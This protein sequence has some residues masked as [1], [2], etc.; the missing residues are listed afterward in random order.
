[1]VKYV[2]N[3]E[4]QRHLSEA[5]GVDALDAATRQMIHSYWTRLA[6]IYALVV[7]AAVLAIFGAYGW[8][9]ALVLPALFF[10]IQLQAEVTRGDLMEYAYNFREQIETVRK[11]ATRQ[12][13]VLARIEAKLGDE[14][15]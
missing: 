1:M 9:V 10:M 15:E 6:V 8:T 3:H 13:R 11:E 4:L 14:Q 7:G 2:Q 12:R 5:G